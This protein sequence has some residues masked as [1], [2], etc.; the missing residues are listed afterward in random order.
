MAS[1]VD[2]RPYFDKD[3]FDAGYSVTYRPGI[4]VFY[5][6][7]KSII[8]TIFNTDAKSSKSNR[9]LRNTY[10]ADLITNSTAGLDSGKTSFWTSLKENTMYVAHKVIRNYLKVIV[11]QPFDMVRL[12][13]QVGSFNVEH[14]TTIE[15]N[16]HVSKNSDNSRTKTT[17]FG[18]GVADPNADITASEAADYFFQNDGKAPKK[19]SEQMTQDQSSKIDR[20]M[21]NL[22]ILK[23]SNAAMT[24]STVELDCNEAHIQPF[25]LSTLD[26][27]SLVISKDGPISLWKATN[28]TFIYQALQKTFESW[29]TGFF[30]PFLDI[31]DPFYIDVGY[32]PDPFRSLLLILIA[33]A[34]TA[35]VLAPLDLIRTKFI[36][37]S[38]KS[39]DRSLTENLSGLRFYFCPVQLIIPT[40]IHSCS[41]NFM[42][43]SIPFALL[44]LTHNNLSGNLYEYTVKLLGDFAELLFKLPTETVLRRL[45]VNY[46]VNQKYNESIKDSIGVEIKE[47]DLIVKFK[48]VNRFFDVFSNGPLFRGW[49]VGIW[50]VFGRWGL[51]LVKNSDLKLIEEKF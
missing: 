50:S 10:E 43:S 5:P 47:D 40:V 4:G 8:D 21:E 48:R 13:L 51:W 23:E 35:V 11:N 22:K 45:Q 42:K 34:V 49:K 12:L 38:S 24:T 2:P 46:L 31:P 6:T 18:S 1:S 39:D 25:S 27:M 3:T 7:G 30:S 26:V 9:F 29:L 37:T 19:D 33:S 32:S 28:V 17:G 16:S 41:H 44:K 14:E 20:T 36:V 15:Y